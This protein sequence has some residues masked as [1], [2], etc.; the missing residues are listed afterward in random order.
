MTNRTKRNKSLINFSLFGVILG[1]ILIFISCPESF[2]QENRSTPVES[3]YGLIRV[4]FIGEGSERTVLPSIAFSKYEYTFSKAGGNSV[5]KTPD[6]SGFFALEIGNYTVTVK[7][8]AG[9]EESYT[10]AANGISSQFTVGSG[11]NST[12]EVRLSSINTIEKGQ[13]SYTITYPTGASAD[14]Y[15]LNWIDNS[16]VAL[17]PVTQVNSKSQILQLEQGSYLF[18]ILIKKD[19]LYA[20][21]SEAIHINSLITTEYTKQFSDD[22]LLE[23][24]TPLSSD[25]DISGIGTFLYDGNQRSVIVTPMANASFGAITIYYEGTGGASYA[26]STTAPTNIGTYNI[27][28]DV[29][30][31]SGWNS[32]IGLPIGVIT[33]NVPVIT[34]TTQPSNRNLT[35]GSISGN[36]SV[37]ASVTNSATLSYQWYSNTIDSNSDGTVISGATGSNYS[38]PTALSVGVYYY[39][40]EVRA[41]GDALPVRSNVATIEVVY[42]K[43]NAQLPI[44]TT[45]PVSATIN[46]YI[47]HTLSVTAVSP[48]GG[49]LYY[50]WR[51]TTSPS[52]S[53]GILVTETSISPNFYPPTDKTG[54]FYY[55][56]E[57][58][59]QIPDN[60][61]GGIKLGYRTSNPVALT[62]METS[63]PV[64]SI[65]THPVNKY[66]SHG[67][68]YDSLSVSASVTNDAVLSY[69]W[70]SNTTNSNVGGTVI[71]G[72]VNSSFNIPTTLTAGVYFYFVEV[73][74]SNG[75]T[76][77]RSNAATVSVR[78]VTL[79]SLSH[80]DKYY[81]G[82]TERSLPGGDYSG[83]AIVYANDEVYIAGKENGA[84][85]WKG[86]T[87]IALPVPS[88]ATYSIATSITVI[89]GVVYTAGYYSR[90]SSINYDIKTSRACYWIGTTRVDLPSP[91]DSMPSR[92]TSI[93]VANGIVYT[94]G[95][96][97]ENA[98]VNGLVSNEIACYWQGTT[99]VDLSN[100]R[101]SSRANI[102]T[103]VDGIVYTAGAHNTI[104][105]Y[106]S[107]PCYWRETIRIDLPIPESSE[108]RMGADLR[109]ITAINVVN[110]V[111][112]TTGG[113][114]SNNLSG[115]NISTLC[116]WQGTT[117]IYLHS[118]I[119]TDIMSLPNITTISVVDGM[120]YTAGR[121]KVE[122][123]NSHYYGGIC[124]WRGT[125]RIDITNNSSGIILSQYMLIE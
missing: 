3:G 14:I 94:S 119:Y 88:D 15:L 18:T 16:T 122:Y 103:V 54:T 69:Q 125:S 111:V 116:Y 6:N 102:I 76:S 61:D 40:V 20:G 68:V 123:I 53:G 73:R 124:Y 71:N 7:A 37:V 63:R 34:I 58:F 51:S 106:Y 11:N 62:V 99:R 30:A 87:R 92:A 26:K 96:Y 98:T 74:G 97:F 77:V 22:D 101:I 23:A 59:N 67:N 65:N 12:V 31:V 33:I 17:N 89:N 107:T 44:I 8:Y 27:T 66:F 5:E 24:R 115:S 120:V 75:A 13:F 46:A 45:Q 50:Q 79:Y 78:T 85:Y 29:E 19:G 117:R 64:I 70:Y 100:D 81:I 83:Q 82:A 104:G 41:T 35:V 2:Y 55:Y 114:I 28:I 10:L 121:V 39:F 25:Y 118:E 43:I 52:T 80:R 48:D 1:C 86:T 60:G 56:V 36:L 109:G 84:C 21:V 112:Y 47:A 108:A 42:P 9:N 113:Y 93:T 4:N 95:S 91:S 90:G 105:S 32:I 57:V 49:T 72:A 38:I 110:G